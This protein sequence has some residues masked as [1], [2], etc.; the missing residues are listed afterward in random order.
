MTVA[1]PPLVPFR[2][3]RYQIVFISAALL[4]VAA[5]AG[6]QTNGGAL[7]GRVTDE[8]RQP[9][10]GVDVTATEV[11]SG[12][13]RTLRTASDGRYR[14]PSLPTG[15]Y[16][17]TAARAGYA[18]VS[19][20]KIDLL[21]GVAHHVDV[22][23]RH[24]T[25][26]EEITITAP[27]RVIESGPPTGIVVAHELIANVPLRNRSIDEFAALAPFDDPASTR[28][29]AETILDGAT[30]VSD[31][32][33]DA[34]D[35]INAMTQQ[36]PAEY[37]RT[38]G[39]VVLVTT[40]KG[41]NDI[42]GS[43]FAIHRNHAGGLQWGAAAGGAIVQ[44]VAHAF[45]AVERDPLERNR[46]FAAANADL[47]SR[48]FGEAEYGNQSESGSLR[49]LWLVH[50]FLWND[51]T[52]RSASGG[53]EIR[54]SM[55]GSFTGTQVRNDWVGGVAAFPEG[56]S[57]YFLQDHIMM[58][59]LVVGAGV[60]YDHQDGASGFSPRLG[61]TYDVNGSGRN[62]LRASFGRYR[63]PDSNEASL[64]Y[65]WQ[66][67]PWIAINVDA[68]HSERGDRQRDAAAVSSQIRFGTFVSV[69]GS[70]TYTSRAADDE[71]R[72]AASVAGT[73]QLPAGFWLSGIGRYRSGSRATARLAGTDLRAA[74]TF[75]LDRG[76]AI[77]LLADVFNVFA[78]SRRLDANRRTGQF[79]IRVNF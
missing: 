42:E 7:A 56:G 18:T 32:P 33:I 35:Q 34:I 53:T 76:F 9:V 6:A 46:V 55:A 16:E 28:R 36:Y 43:A 57:G 64:G 69:A 24:V 2:A 29:P 45:A 15:T 47:S 74:K 78:Q 8:R 38:S 75:A 61:L 39:G 58:R 62:L 3:M 60:R 66:A 51:L 21:L 30:A 71:P 4:F 10:A 77:D 26:E 59:K 44:D 20:R 63:N 52:V 12:L 54:E 23:L 13:S 11:S 50:R 5:L 41:S 25:G 68:L 22:R 79:G 31:V 67:N 65:S 72:H 49:D 19:I 70:Y 37:G 14:F 48:H 17:L 1:R 27:V 40:R 73:L